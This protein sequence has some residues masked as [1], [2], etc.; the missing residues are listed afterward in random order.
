MNINEHILG[1]NAVVITLMVILVQWVLMAMDRIEHIYDILEKMDKN[2]NTNYVI[3]N[4][5]I[6]VEEEPNVKKQN[7]AEN[8]AENDE[9]AKYAMPPSDTRWE[10]YDVP[11]P[12]KND[13]ESDN[14]ESD[15][16]D[17]SDEEQET[18]ENDD[19]DNNELKDPKTWYGL[20]NGHARYKGEWKNGKPNGDGIMEFFEGNFQ[21][22]ETQDELISHSIIE[23]SFVN[24][25]AEGY[26]KQFYDQ[27]ID[28]GETSIPF[29]AGE[30]KKNLQHG[31]GTH[32]FGNGCYLKGNFKKGKVH[33]RAIYYDCETKKTR[34]GKYKNDVRISYVEVNGEL[35]C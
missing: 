20:Y 28:K 10:G 1:I 33:G 5:K 25:Y 16:E 35:L 29:Y 19:N 14:N 12:Q 15:E 8:D 6:E 9:L 31:H 22:G 23:C 11:E 7:D 21:N 27:E 17:K 13:D 4:K 32:Y 34:I 24:G 26:G 30:F 3:K 2:N 18:K